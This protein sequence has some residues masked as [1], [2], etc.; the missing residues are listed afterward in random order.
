MTRLRKRDKVDKFLEK[1]DKV[2]TRSCLIGGFFG[3]IL[4]GYLRSR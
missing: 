4:I 1:Y 3:G 2:I